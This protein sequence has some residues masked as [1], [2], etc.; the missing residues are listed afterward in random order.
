MEGFIMDGVV[1]DR[2]RAVRGGWT[3]MTAA[4]S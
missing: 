4:C 1:W 3:P 2:N